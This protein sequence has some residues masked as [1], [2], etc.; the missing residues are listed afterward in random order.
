M[1]R[2]GV[3]IGRADGGVVIVAA[4]GAVKAKAGCIDRKK[5]VKVV[6][7]AGEAQRGLTRSAIAVKG[8]T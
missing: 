5:C 7:L 4:T 3:G 1:A 2:V 8:L 6:G